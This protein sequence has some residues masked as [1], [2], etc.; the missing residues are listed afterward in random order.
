M[1]EEAEKKSPIEEI[2]KAMD[3]SEKQFTQLSLNIAAGQEQIEQLK[4][5]RDTEIAVFSALKFALDKLK[6]E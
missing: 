6:E 2:Q 3:A 4:K 5:Q 1:T